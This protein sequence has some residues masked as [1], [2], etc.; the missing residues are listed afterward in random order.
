[1]GL[2]GLWAE[3]LRW[4]HRA[5]L[6]APPAGPAPAAAPRRTGYLPPDEFAA[7]VMLISRHEAIRQARLHIFS[8]A[9]FRQA[10]GKKWDR[11]AGLVDI[12]AD[13][14]ISR[15]IDPATDLFTRID[16]EISCLALPN[17]SRRQARATVAAIAHD[18]THQLFGNG[19]VGGSRPQVWAS[20]LPLD[21]AVTADGALD[22]T[23]VRSTAAASRAA[24]APPLP[25]G[26]ATEA[27]AAMAAP[28]RATLAAMLSEAD[29]VGL[30]VTASDLSAFAIS[31]GWKDR[32]EATEVPGGLDPTPARGPPALPV[33]ASARSRRERPAEAEEAPD[34]LDTQL[35]ERAEAALA[36]ERRMAPTSNLTLVWTPIWVTNR[37][38]VGA[39]QARVIRVDRE[40]APPLEGV[41]AYAGAAPVEALALDRFVATQ[42]ARELKELYFGGQR[43]GL[44]VPIHWMSLA[45]RW[46]D[47]IRMPI[48]DCPPAARR[49]LL[50]IE[51]FGLSPSMPRAILHDLVDPLEKLGCDILARLPLA[52]AEMALTLRSVRAI[53]VDLAELN[54]DERAGDDE[55][56][57]RL[58]RFRDTARQARVACYVWGVRRRPLIAR[59]VRAGFSLVNGPGIMADVSH[60]QPA[61]GAKRAA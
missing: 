45:P 1:M 33:P 61:E 42:A 41:H 4:F 53:G 26:G 34:W 29:S 7:E 28:H 19:V 22:E 59:L 44:T 5:S 27:A 31:G 13:A 56:F 60:P 57:A 47:C 36:A 35:E 58:E 9:D 3:F 10:V 20:N 49:R 18:L 17:A 15:H 21:R 30:E 6:P 48:E 37:M 23:A 2:A 38:A 12:L 8:L 50:K 52:A 51:I 54:D 46:R 55:L 11:L 25:A 40:G 14:T 43:V 39:F 32:P 24:L 16:A